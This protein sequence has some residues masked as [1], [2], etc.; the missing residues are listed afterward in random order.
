M[1]V[2]HLIDSMGFGGAQ[3]VVKGYFEVQEVN[4]NIYLYALRPKKNSIEIF[5]KNINLI[6][7]KNK[8]SLL[9][10]IE[11]KNYIENENIDVLHC[12]LLRSNVFGWLIKKIWF[13]NLKL[14]IH[15]HGGI[16]VE[17]ILYSLATRII[18]SKVNIFI[19]VSKNIKE[20]LINC[21]I[22]SKK[23]VIIHNFVDLSKFSRCSITWDVENERLQHGY[24]N[25]TYVIGFAGRIVESKGW[26]E[27]VEAAGYIIKCRSDIKFLIAGD[28]KDY[29]E[30]DNYIKKHN[31]KKDVIL[32]GHVKNMLWFYSL[33]DCF[34]FPSHREGMP[35]TQLEVIA[36]NIPLISAISPGLTEVVDKN[37]N[38]DSYFEKGNVIELQDKIIKHVD[39]QVKKINVNIELFSIDNFVKKINNLYERL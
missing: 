36:L 27:F 4:E 19:A 39:N 16:G 20:S 35:M 24:N 32:L 33:I 29:I 15:E 21:G 34:V 37:L 6:K 7:T 26:R 1:K 14:V 30:L 8:F 38:Q 11:I 25:N 12:H 17:G 31:L 13:P 2:L 18:Q 22:S 3:T 10:L 28:G 23:I 5:H 9:P